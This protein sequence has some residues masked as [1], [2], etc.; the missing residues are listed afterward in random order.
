[1]MLGEN[2][3]PKI[4]ID[5]KE[6]ELEGFVVSELKHLYMRIY[7]RNENRW[8]NIHIQK[9]YNEKDNLFKTLIKNA[10]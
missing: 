1:M 10:D 9:N 8:S 7:N 3:S 6:W 5:N 4:I 2:E